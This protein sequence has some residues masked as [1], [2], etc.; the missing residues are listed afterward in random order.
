MEQL[1]LEAKILLDA[2]LNMRDV[3]SPVYLLHN[4]EKNIE[5]LTGKSGT[6]M[7]EVWDKMIKDGIV[8]QKDDKWFIAQNYIEKIKETIQEYLS[9][10][11]VT[12]DR[13][14]DLIEEEIQKTPGKISIFVKLLGRIYKSG[15]NKSI[16]FADG[17][18]NN[19]LGKLCDELVK[20]RLAFRYDVISS[21]YINRTFYL[22][23]W[24]FDVEE[25][26]RNIVFRHLNIEGLTDEEWSIISLLLISQESLEYQVIKNNINLTD[27]ELREIITNLRERGLITE[28][29]GRV[30]LL[31]GI[32]EPLNQY[33]KSIFYQ[34]LKS[35]IISQLKQRIGSSLSVLWLFITAKMIYNLPYG[36][37]IDEL[38]L[39]KKIS[40][41]QIEE[42]KNQLVNIKDIGIL[43]DLGSD[44]VLLGDIIR[45]V[46]NWL[47]SSIKQS[48]IFI[49]ARDYYLARSVFQDI[50]SK[51]QVYVKIQD[52]YLG[53]ETF[54][55]LEYIPI[56]LQIMI[57]TGLKLG[58]GEDVNRIFERIEQMRTQRRGKFQIWFIGDKTTG[59]APFHDRFIISKTRGWQIGTSLKQ[60]GK[61]KETTI[62]ELS[63]YEKEETIEPAFDRWWNAKASE[64]E[65]KNIRKMDYQEWKE[66]IIKGGEI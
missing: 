19:D 46:E 18:W 45:D 35:K 16:T 47:K 43:Y 12:A 33:F 54:D 58:E 37:I 66:N 5:I 21:R 65:L 6:D 22:R 3:Y 64:L 39:S 28:V 44:V 42:F 15:D 48:L 4:I 61:G 1:P 53:E 50:F 40:K 56:E 55:L 17:E 9:E 38:I 13:V 57:L 34:K 8:L 25:I 52:P 26:I 59:E 60:V 41:M 36:V 62:S 14:I 10:N 31:E 2:I 27:P 30:D 49:P 32:K 24:P 23:I 29:Y 51:C 20:K 7:R 11:Q 63:K